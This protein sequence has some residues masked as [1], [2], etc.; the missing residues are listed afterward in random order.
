MNPTQFSLDM[1]AY[2]NGTIDING[3][4]AL[5]Q[6]ADKVKT[7]NTQAYYAAFSIRKVRPRLNSLDLFEMFLTMPFS[8]QP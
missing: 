6:A 7:N 2:K 8:F 1:N 3:F 4:L 5:N